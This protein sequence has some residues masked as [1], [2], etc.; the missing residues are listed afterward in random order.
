LRGKGQ[1]RRVED[2]WNRCCLR[3]RESPGKEHDRQRQ[4]Q[5]CHVKRTPNGASTFRNALKCDIPG[6]S[7][8]A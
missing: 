5:E 4:G 2:D 6:S 7:I 3:S 1:I 8:R